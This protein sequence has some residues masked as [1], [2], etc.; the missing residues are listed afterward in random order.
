MLTEEELNT[1]FKQLY[2][3]FSKRSGDSLNDVNELLDLTHALPAPWYSKAKIAEAHF[4][5]TV[6]ND[7]IHTLELCRSILTLI[8]QQKAAR[9]GGRALS[10]R[11]YSLS[12]INRTSTIRLSSIRVKLL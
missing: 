4:Y 12:T 6:K 1:R 2:L 7:Y 11:N 10:E 9:Q 3:R 8:T 5:L